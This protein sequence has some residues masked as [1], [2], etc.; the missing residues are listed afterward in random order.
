MLPLLWRKCST[1]CCQQSFG[2]LWPPIQNSELACRIPGASGAKA[3]LPRFPNLCFGWRNFWGWSSSA[4]VDCTHRIAFHVFC[5]SWPIHGPVVFVTKSSRQMILKPWPCQ[6]FEQAQ[7]PTVDFN[8]YA[9]F[10]TGACSCQLASEGSR[11][12]QGAFAALPVTVLQ[13]LVP[14]GQPV[15]E[16]NCCVMMLIMM[17]LLLLL[18]FF[19]FAV[20]VAG[21]VWIRK[22]LGI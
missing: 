5:R 10:F 20:A 7:P 11:T 8:H 19:V 4:F 1:K 21:R 18:L 2:A 16:T 15:R 9:A 6:P 3:I 12:V 14:H 17:P 22:T 13:T